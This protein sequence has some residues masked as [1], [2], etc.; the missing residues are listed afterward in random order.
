VIIRSGRERHDS[1][2]QLK[3]LGIGQ[4]RLGRGGSS[5]GVGGRSTEEPAT[6]AAPAN[7]KQG[8][9]HAQEP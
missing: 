1:M 7:A 9:T 4:A 3:P 5:I 2:Q 8:M 6:R